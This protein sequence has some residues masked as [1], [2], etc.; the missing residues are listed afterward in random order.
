MRCPEPS[1]SAIRR[2]FVGPS[3]MRC[4]QAEIGRARLAGGSRKR[5]LAGG[6]PGAFRRFAGLA[7]GAVNAEAAVRG[8]GR[9]NRTARGGL[10]RRAIVRGHG[11]RLA[12]VD[13]K[14]I[15]TRPIATVGWRRISTGW[16]ARFL[17]DVS[18]ITVY[19]S[20]ENISWRDGS[21]AF[22]LGNSASRIVTPRT[23]VYRLAVRPIRMARR[24]GGKGWRR[25]RTRAASP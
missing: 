25:I 13:V 24:P 17:A 9:R 8:R 19:P 2:A 22:C 1:G 21:S 11:L 3:C 18:T 12:T 5:R 6:D 10:P 15:S 7:C 20:S 23:L 16:R 14:D 4:P